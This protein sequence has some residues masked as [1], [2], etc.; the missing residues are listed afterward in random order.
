MT[1]FTSLLWPKKRD[2]CMTPKSWFGTLIGV[3]FIQLLP[4]STV[5]SI[6]HPQRFQLS[7]EESQRSVPS[8][9]RRG[10]LRTGPKM[11]AGRS[12]ASDHFFPWDIERFKKPDHSRGFLP[13]L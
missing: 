5:A 7:I 12:S 3:L 11:P 6:Q 10:L 2:G 8:F 9:K 13:P 1:I 4:P